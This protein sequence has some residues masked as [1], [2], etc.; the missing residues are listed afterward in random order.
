MR[1]ML[2][3]LVCV[4]GLGVQPGFGQSACDSVGGNLIHNCGFET[5]DFTGWNVTGALTGSDLSVSAASNS[6]DVHWDG[7]DILSTSGTK[8][9]YTEYTFLLGGIGNDILQLSGQEPLHGNYNVDDAVVAGSVSAPEPAS[10]MLVGTLLGLI[11]LVRRIA[12]SSPR[13]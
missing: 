12:A 2:C 7:N 6:F 10:V 3:G 1:R 9:G 4:V 5:G 8:F 11:L 13:R